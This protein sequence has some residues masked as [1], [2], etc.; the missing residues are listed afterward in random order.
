ME[1]D[2]YIK[3]VFSLCSFK[4]LLHCLILLVLTLQMDPLILRPERRQEFLDKFRILTLLAWNLLTTGRDAKSTRYGCDVMWLRVD[5]I[6]S[7]PI[8][9]SVLRLKWYPAW[10]SWLPALLAVHIKTLHRSL[11]TRLCSIDLFV[12]DLGVAQAD[13]PGWTKCKEILKMKKWPLEFVKQVWRC[14]DEDGGCWR[15][16]KIVLRCVG[17]LQ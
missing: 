6:N 16:A 9:H 1:W 4:V 7:H 10:L 3:E 8:I 12:G 2:Y 5:R 17:E 11:D 14:G 13:R 15:P